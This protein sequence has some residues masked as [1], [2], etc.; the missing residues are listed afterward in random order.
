[1]FHIQ[2]AIR[3]PGMRPRRK[4]LAQ[5]GAVVLAASGL[6]VASTITA[7]AAVTDFFELDGNVLNDTTS[8]PPDWQDLFTTGDVTSPY[9]T[10]ATQAASL[11]T[12]FVSSSF[13]RDFTPGSTADSSTY[14][15]GSKDT[16]DITPGW[17][18]KKSNNV[19]DKGD[20][21]NT[22]MAPYRASNGDLIVYAGL[23]KNAPNGD[24]NMAVWLLK[25]GTVG[26]TA[27]G[28]NTAFSGSHQNGDV[29]LVA[30]FLNGGLNPQITGYTWQDGVLDPIANGTGGKC[31]TGNANLCA[32]TNTAAD[33]TTPWVTDDKSLG[34]GTDLGT[35]QFYEMGANLTQL[36]VSGC[37]ANYIANTRSSQQTTATLYDFAGGHAPTCGSLAVD[38]YIDAN[39]DGALNTGVG[40]TDVTTGTVV[41]GWSFTV[42]GPGGLSCTGT[43]TSTAGA[44]GTV[45]CSASTSTADQARTTLTNMS[46]GSY[47]ITET[48]RTGFFNTDPGAIPNTGATVSKV[49]NLTTSGATV[50]F[51][52]TCF[53]AKTF[54]VT[55][56]PSS[57][58]SVTA[59]Y[60]ITAGPNTSTTN[61]DVTLTKQ[62]TTSTWQA[63]ATGPLYQTN[64]I[65]WSWFINGDSAHAV[66]GQTGESLASFGYPTCGNTNTTA[67]LP[68]S[69]SG[70]KFKDLNGNGTKDAGEPPLGNFDFKLMSADATPVQVGTTQTSATNGT[71]SFANVPPGSYTI[72]EVG[73]PTGWAAT[74]FA[75]G[76][77]VTVLLN[78]PAT[79]T[80]TPFG[81][82]PLSKIQVN[83]LPQAKSPP[84]S[85]A[86]ATKATSISCTDP[87]TPT[88]VNVGSNTNTDTL[89]TGNLTLNQSS[90]TCVITYIDP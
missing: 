45:N 4:R 74:N 82:W 58:T 33:I 84:G 53:V 55:N 18:C 62:G 1:M 10:V 48:Q 85:T 29:L 7:S 49:I 78:G 43:T 59:R 41:A 66:T 64:T 35:D 88:P 24:N 20:I 14:A 8:T 25:D 21:Q 73:P 71:F 6:V 89:T 72:V 60:V 63:V 26:C 23:E 51:G 87:T 65:S 70:S 54:Q 52:N 36:G 83:F 76:Q 47:T 28:G 34:T 39:M 86:N 12:G 90:V 31:G 22:Y 46:P 38:K 16:L 77:S 67:F 50:H 19:T 11:P 13:F 57:A 79:V 5:V 61:H 56:V 2:Q 27:G 9:S 42:T 17:Q 15:T 68:A 40:S 32:I 75:T 44:L 80:T 81:D 37:F 69:I 3:A 30:A